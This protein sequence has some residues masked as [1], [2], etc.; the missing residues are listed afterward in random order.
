MHPTHQIVSQLVETLFLR[1]SCHGISE[2]P[3]GV[4]CDGEDSLCMFFGVE[5][6]VFHAPVEYKSDIFDYI[7][8]IG[9][10]LLLKG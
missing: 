5:F 2:A 10:F 4:L 3:Y 7:P 1:R 6:E 9:L 8:C